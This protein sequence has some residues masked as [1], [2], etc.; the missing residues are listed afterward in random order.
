MLR[1][2]PGQ[3]QRWG[4]HTVEKAQPPKLPKD[5]GV[6]EELPQQAPWK[7]QSHIQVL[8]SFEAVLDKMLYDAEVSV[9]KATDFSTLHTPLL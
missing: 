2:L 1:S 8:L 7:R 3:L 6:L 4:G 9:L 5:S